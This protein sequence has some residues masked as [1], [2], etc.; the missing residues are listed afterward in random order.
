MQV[1][2]VMTESCEF[3]SPNATLQQAA[4]TMRDLDCGFLAIGSEDKGKLEGVITDRDIVIRAIANGDDPKETMVGSVETPRVLY[5]YQDD[6]LQSAANTMRE[7]QVHR[8]VV[9][10]SPDSKQLCGVISLGDILR[11]NE[12]QVAAD[13]AAGIASDAA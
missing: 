9:L 7:Q 12:R 10:N 3:I 13:A 11:H 6:D 1:K 5:C 8:L 4:Q 2:N